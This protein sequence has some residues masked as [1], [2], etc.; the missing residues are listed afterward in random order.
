MTLCL[1]ADPPPGVL[2]LSPGS[3]LVLTCSG[4]VAVDGV[5]VNVEKERSSNRKDSSAFEP[6]TALNITHTKRTAD[7]LKNDSSFL[8]TGVRTA[9]GE[10][11]NP[12]NTDTNSHTSPPTTLTALTTRYGKGVKGRADALEDFVEGDY[13]EEDD[14]EEEGGEEG[15]RVTRGIKSRFLW[16][17]NGKHLG[18]EGRD[19]TEVMLSLFAVRE[20]DTGRYTC[21]RR[22]RERFSLKV[23]ISGECKQQR[24]RKSHGPFILNH[25][26]FQTIS[27]TSAL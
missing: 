13:E 8:K 12:R 24:P 25:R 17:W 14:D 26:I 7:Y 6:T 9:R 21:Y 18:A 3:H 23:I 16:K 22:G 2:V 27:R 10:S 15:R 5:K 1:S 11:K 20:A 4:D 19:W